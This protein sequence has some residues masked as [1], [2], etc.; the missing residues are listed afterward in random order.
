M[1]LLLSRCFCSKSIWAADFLAALPARDSE[2]TASVFFQTLRGTP[3]IQPQLGPVARDTML[4]LCL[5]GL[6][7]RPR[8][9]LVR[10]CTL[11]IGNFLCRQ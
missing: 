9:A 6:G 10:A 4:H 1:L 8:S 7:V 5:F 11:H 3:G 2:S